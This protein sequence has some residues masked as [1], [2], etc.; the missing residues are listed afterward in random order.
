MP[1][2]DIHELFERFKSGGPLTIPAGPDAARRTSERRR[3]IRLSAAAAAAVVVTVAASV[4]AYDLVPRGGTTEVTS[5]PTPTGPPPTPTVTDTPTSSPSP[6]S[7]GQPTEG[8][9]AP[10][11]Q[12]S[13]VPERYRYEGDS[14]RGDWIVEFAASLCAPPHNLATVPTPTTQWEAAFRNG[15]TAEAPAI[16]QRVVDYVGADTARD[17]VDAVRRMAQECVQVIG[18]PKTWM[19]MHQAFAGDE[20]I[21]LRWSGSG[22]S[23]IYVVV[24]VAGLVTQIAY[25]ESDLI[26]PIRIGQR[27]ADRLCTA[28]ATC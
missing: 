19:V 22:R 26:D 18:E 16:Y 20:A 21:V 13:D 14:I 7:D 2:V 23:T 24:R 5:S 9:A 1:E 17:Y 10:T 11:L 4:V 8:P 15:L 3:R 27:A 12:Q 28:A 25:P 6:T